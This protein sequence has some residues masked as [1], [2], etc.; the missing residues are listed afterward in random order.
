MKPSEIFETP[1]ASGF[2]KV[3]LKDKD[4]EEIVEDM[5]DKLD[6]DCWSPECACTGSEKAEA[7]LRETLTTLH[8]KHTEELERAVK[9]ERERIVQA[10]STVADSKTYTTTGERLHHIGL[11]LQALT[12]TKTDEQTEV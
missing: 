8:Q 11:M 4:I 3:I 7:W 1:E 6:L 9:A 12:P 2:D 10:I 5:R